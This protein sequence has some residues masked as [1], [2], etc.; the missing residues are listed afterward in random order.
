MVAAPRC[1]R[2]FH[3]TTHCLLLSGPAGSWSQVTVG[4]GPRL[5][6]GVPH[7]CHHGECLCH[8][9]PCLPGPSHPPC[10][11]IWRPR[12]L[13]RVV[14]ALYIRHMPS[15]M[16]AHDFSRPPVVCPLA[17]V[18]YMVQAFSLYREVFMPSSMRHSLKV[19]AYAI[20][21]GVAA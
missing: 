18:V 8:C 2:H 13:L 10:P 16:L 3:I 11:Y 20:G 7:L 21:S 14:A 19:R 12:S 4:W 9:L 6:W 17:F 5:G 15:S 1:L